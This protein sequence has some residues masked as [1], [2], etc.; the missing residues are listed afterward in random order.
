TRSTSSAGSA[1]TSTRP[2]TSSTQQAG[3]PRSSQ[4]PPPWSSGLSSTCW[5]DNPVV[6]RVARKGRSFKGAGLYYL[7]DK[8]ALTAERVAFTHTENLPTR[9]AEKAIR[10]M[11]YTAMR[12]AELKARAGGSGRGSKLELPVYSYSLSWA[13]GEDPSQEEMIEAAKAT[14]RELG[15]AGHEA[16]FIAHNDEPHPHIHL[17]VNRVHPETGI[18]AKLSKDRLKLSAW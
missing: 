15:L 14:L 8:G 3:F 2:F 4:A 1:S 11:A 16:L 5:S 13:P 17:V 6:P 12:E 18:A 9:D 7:H 10:F